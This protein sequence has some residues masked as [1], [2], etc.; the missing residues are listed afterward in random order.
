MAVTPTTMTELNDLAK[1]YFSNVYQNLMNTEV[2]LKGQF[3]RLEGATFTGKKWIFG[4]KTSVGGGAANAGANKSLPAADEGQYDQGEATLVRTYTRMALDLLAAEV[5]KQQAGSYRPA[6]A[7]TMADRLEAHDLEVN[8]QLF[9]AGDGKV[10]IVTTG[11]NNV[12]QTLSKDYGVTNG[13]SGTRH[14]YAG[15]QVEFYSS[16]GTTKRAGGPFTVSS[17]DSTTQITL[18][19]A[20][21]TTT[22]DFVTKAT[23]DTD[24]KTAGEANGLLT[25]VKSSGTFEAIP[26]T[27]R[28]KSTVDSNSGNL[29]DLTDAIILKTLA[30]VRAASRKVPNLAVCRP[31]VVLKYSETFL[32]LR[33]IMGQDV[34]LKGGYKPITGIQHAGG[35]I[36]VLEDLDCP[37]SRLFLINTEAFRMADL[38]GAEWFDGDGAQFTRVTDKDAVEGYIRKY[39]QL[40]TVMRN[41]NAVI[42]D[43]N[44]YS[45]ITR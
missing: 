31:G 39:W 29:R 16:D 14:L 44:D 36:P 3:A 35:V 9:C 37:E 22:D 33:R 11:A 32:P 5:T 24:N 41:A 15:D 40:I 18:A 42:E 13:G 4:V 17:V 26:A 27:G 45:A 30:T 7:E 6:I 23:A 28:W 21:N 12:A 8:R 2:P 10:A 43:I 34:E 25:S 1:D 19:A 20:P 38:I